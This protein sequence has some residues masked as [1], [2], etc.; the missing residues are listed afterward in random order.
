MKNLSVCADPFPPY[1]YISSEGRIEGLDYEAVRHFLSVAGYEAEFRIAPWD[2]ISR[3][4]EE[5]KFDIIF[6]VQ[7]T[8]E[9]L[10]KY[11]LSGKLR[12]AVTEV[13]AAD[14]HKKKLTEYS[15]LEDYMLGVIKGFAN[16]EAVDAL[17]DSCKCEYEDT[18]SLLK[19][20]EYGQIDYAVCDRGVRQY[21]RP[22]A[23]YGVSDDLTYLRPLYVMFHDRD[24]RDSFNKAMQ[25]EKGVLS[26]L[27]PKEVFKYF[28]EICRIPHGSFH[29]EAIGDYLVDFAKERGLS[30][31]RDEVGNVIIKKPGTEGKEE[32]APVILQGHMDM[33]LAKADGCTKDME[34]EGPDL[35][36]EGPWISAKGTTLGGDDG[37]ALAMSLAI[38]DSD[39]LAHPPVE[40]VF[41]VNEEVGLIGATE[42]DCTDL[43]GR[44]LINIDSEI[45]GIFTV[46]CAGANDTSIRLPIERTGEKPEK[47]Y[48]IRVSGLIGGHSGMMID[49]GRANAA[50]IM[51]RVL[52]WLSD[53]TELQIVTING[54]LRPNVIPTVCEAVICADDYSKLEW[55]VEEIRRILKAEYSVSDPGIEIS[56]AETTCDREPTT[57]ESTDRIIALLMCIPNGVYLMDPSMA[58]LVQTSLSL[59]VLRTVAANEENSVQIAG[60][61]TDYVETVS[62]IRSSI[63][64]QKEVLVDKI[65]YLSKALGGS[66]DVSGDYPGWAYRENSPLRDVMTCVFEDLYNRKPELG[67]VHCGLECGILCGK[68]ENL[69][70]ISIGPDMPDVHTPN[71]RMSI[72]SVE[73]TFK[74]IVNTL[75]ALE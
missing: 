55:G 44:R 66:I 23:A 62:C 68:M 8:P 18:E 58:G 46:S 38:L 28:E 7:D 32:A 21:L 26:E 51:G 74:L 53:H 13:I 75:A 54:G 43:K 36:V 16:G 20:L 47:S 29:V 1:Q 14:E 24:I 5:K 64:S 70:C 27:N 42:L 30:Y 35:V 63:D 69:D 6:Q 17:P 49:K 12:D 57:K 11:F 48:A 39:T 50:L 34:K 4:F 15:Q 71:E 37:I 19:A 65:R 60:R 25:K 40:A 33:V 67:S 72:S 61:K 3:A 45:E 56:I 52:S 2:E 59:G 22:N 73:R 41:T 9:R 10:E 31:R